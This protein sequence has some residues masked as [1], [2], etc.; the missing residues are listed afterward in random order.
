MAAELTLAQRVELE[1]AKD[2]IQ[3]TNA[4]LE[5][6]ENG[7]VGSPGFHVH[8]TPDEV[9]EAQETIKRLT[10]KDEACACR[11]ADPLLL[12]VALS[13]WPEDEIAFMPWTFVI[14]LT[15]DE[16]AAVAERVA[17]VRRAHPEWADEIRR[18]TWNRGR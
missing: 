5:W 1:R 8:Y 17:E 6:A 13:K 18:R 4:Y 10:E 12:G 3:D 16:K 9:R 11:K 15:D 7:R 2:V 14:G